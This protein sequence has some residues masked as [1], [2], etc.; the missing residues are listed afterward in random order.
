MFDFIGEKKKKK[1]KKSLGEIQAGQ[2]FLMEPSDKKEKL[3]TSQWPL[4]LK[5]GW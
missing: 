5:V 4:L 1:E 2:E 3:D